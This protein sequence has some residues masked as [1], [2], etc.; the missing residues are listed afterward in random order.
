V[1]R[2]APRCAR[3]LAA[4]IALV[5]AGSAHAGPYTESGY[6]PE[7]MQAWASG[8]EDFAR[9]PLDIANPGLGDASHGEPEWALGASEG[10]TFDVFS[11]GD[12]GDL[13]LLVAA[14]ISDG[15]GDDFA[16]FENG[17]FA[18]GG[19]Y[20][21]LA[22]VEVS[23]DGTHFARFPS[24]C[25]RATPVAGGGVIDPSDYHNLAGKHPLG[26]GTGFDLADLAGH[27]LVAGGQLDLDR[28]AYV[29]LVDVIGNGSTLD[30]SGAPVYDPYPTPFAS[31]GHDADAVG[32]LHLPE[33]GRVPLL[34]AGSLALGALA[35]RRRPCAIA[36]C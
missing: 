29:R 25:L 28:V 1:T 18:P 21:E 7:L 34:A 2:R 9:G 15:P 23:S 13:T 8:W 30:G 22:F 27:A 14:G 26:S 6:A 24:A 3:W 32:V 12:G 35:R 10:D 36:G 17:F 11:L 19:F 31:G 33:P 4:G 20:A 5:A 16:V